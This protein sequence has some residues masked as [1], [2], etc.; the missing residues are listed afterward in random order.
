MAE[1]SD[2]EESDAGSPELSPDSD[3]G[4]EEQVQQNLNSP[5][6]SSAISGTTARTSHS[7][8]ELADLSSEEMLDALPDLADA[9]DKLLNHLLFQDVSQSNTERVAKSLQDPR[10]RT[11]K[12]MNRLTSSFVL[13]K[14]VYG[15]EA[16]INIS[17]AIR[18][19][20]GVR[21]MDQVGEGPWRPDDI[22]YKANLA[23][24]VMNMLSIPPHSNQPFLE[25]MERDFPAPFLSQLVTTKES[26]KSS[27]A[28]V[29]VNDTFEA[30]FQ[31][32]VQFFLSML[33]RN[34]G[35]SGFDPDNLLSAVFYED[36]SSIKGWDV[37]GLR[38]Q[39]LNKWQINTITERLERIQGNF[40]G[41][42]VVD[43]DALK[44]AYPWTTCLSNLVSWAILRK[45]EIEAHLTSCGGVGNIKERLGQEA[46]HRA[47][48]MAGS[49]EKSSGGESP[50]IE[51]YYPPL[52][53]LSHPASDQVEPLNVVVDQI[54]RSA[55]KVTPG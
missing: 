30:A 36:P 21:R 46:L 20:L 17:I 33:G 51:I 25:K 15:N 11:R 42:Q 43:I 23:N 41:E 9:S 18:G 14:E 40:D 1:D 22:L 16:Y 45:D 31:L 19:V 32:R 39:D 28:S 44:L 8:Q 53:E 50:R 24:M 4:D 35:Q 10:S 52:S 26:A 47:E 7:A 37:D 55:S 27:G 3:G 29:L 34:Q 2:Y 54:V 48:V 38:S 12:T 6:A 49:R 5:G 13:H